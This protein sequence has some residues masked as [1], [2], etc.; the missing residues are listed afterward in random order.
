MSGS[1]HIDLICLA[2]VL[3]TLLLTV[4]FINGEAL[5]IAVIADGDAGDGQFTANDLD[6]DWDRAGAAKIT[7]TGGG[8][9]ISGS[10]AY[11]YG[12]DVH[13]ARA[14][15]YILFGELS[16]GS[17]IV[18]ADKNDKIWLLFD[19]VSLN[20]PDG[21]AVLIE[22][23]GKVFITL[24]A[25]TENSV[26]SGAEYSAGAI[27]AGIDAAIY[28]RDDLTINGSGSLSVSAEYKHGIVCNDDLV[29]TGGNISI[30]AAGDGLH[31]N[32]S[33]RIT[34]AELTINAGD[35]GIT[36][37]NDEETGYVYIASGSI[38]IPSCY[39]GIEAVDITIAGGTLDIVPT[40][41]GINANGRGAG[42]VIRISG[43]EISIINETGRDADGLDSNGD[44]F[45]S[46]G[47][48]L[49]SVS[50]SGGNCAIDYGS[51]NGGVCEISGGTVV[52]A[53]SSTMAEGFDSASGQCFIMRSTPTAPA[54]TALSLRN[55]AGK[56]LVSEAIPCSFSSVVISTPEL[57]MG[58]TCTLSIDG[59]EEEVIVDNSAGSG[60]FAVAGMFGGGR[61]QSDR[62]TFGEAPQPFDRQEDGMP[63]GSMPED[64]GGGRWNGMTPD[65][66]KGGLEDRDLAQN[67]PQA[68]TPGANLE[69]APGLIVSVAVLCLG[70]AFALFFKRR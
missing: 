24:A 12:G 69:F 60:G 29:I 48:L 32:D 21:A 31:A 45:I 17:V 8:A 28:S 47:K 52:A 56:E 3:L 30:T 2:A 68:E 44:I 22:Q 13:I 35:D 4:L 67:A 36:V 59:R 37:S 38:S 7:L 10:G 57:E 14:G 70:L 49:I 27:A 39:E 33:A 42:S 11:V 64:F 16:D 62:N 66:S 23:A 26:S 43:G 34:G 54:G 40:D 15:K 9:D 20:C 25:G 5:G 50:S 63:G 53:G 1:K 19:G 65:G 51:E 6:G 58:E 46:G 55:Q 61:G 18:D 41:D